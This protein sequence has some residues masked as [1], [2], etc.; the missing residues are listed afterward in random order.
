MKLNTKQK[1]AVFDLSGNALI[2]ASPGSGKTRTLVARAIH[3]LDILP[4]HKSIALITT[5]HHFEPF[6]RTNHQ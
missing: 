6:C 2:T 1:I 3:N 5:S 4:K